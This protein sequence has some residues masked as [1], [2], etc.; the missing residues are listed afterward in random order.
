MGR[1]RRLELCMHRPAQT[2]P[3]GSLALVFVCRD[4]QSWTVERWFLSSLEC[5]QTRIGL[6]QFAV[7]IPETR[8]DA[9]VRDERVFPENPPGSSVVK[10]QKLENSKAVENPMLSMACNVRGEAR[11]ERN[12][13]R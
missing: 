8:R 10:V 1:W 4:G 2:W 3:R 12:Q 7:T 9:S 6:E 5:V 11:Q 13:A